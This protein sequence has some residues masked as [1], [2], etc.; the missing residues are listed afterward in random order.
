MTNGRNQY[1]ILRRGIL[2]PVEGQVS[3]INV[4]KNGVVSIARSSGSSKKTQR[5]SQKK[6]G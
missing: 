4:N 6:P 1:Q 5:T 2:G 3:N